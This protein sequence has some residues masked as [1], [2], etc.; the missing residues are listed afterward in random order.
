MSDTA[1]W[2]AALRGRESSRPDA[3]YEDPL[4]TLLAG[5]HGEALTGTIRGSRFVQWV[6]ALRT[7]A[8]DR[9]IASALS[10]GADTIVNLGAGM[11]TRPYRL[12]LP[13]SVRWFE[14]DFPALIERKRA[15]LQSYAPSCRLQLVPLDLT[16]RSARRELLESVGKGAKSIV[17]LTEGV[18]PYLVP[19]EVDRLAFDLCSAG[20]VDY[21]IQDYYNGALSGGGMRIW[22]DQFRD[23]PVHFESSDWFQYFDSRGW[24]LRENIRLADESDRLRRRPP[25]SLPVLLAWLLT[26]ARTHYGVRDRMGYALFQN[27]RASQ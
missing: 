17:V 24:A 13:E 16:Q 1:L 5:P 2:V 18:L 25:L 22:D 4:A 7:V 12:S 9:L 3:L 11:D 10:R 6:M 14:V 8:I 21:W 19:D 15:A 23:A 20:N 26:P 27:A